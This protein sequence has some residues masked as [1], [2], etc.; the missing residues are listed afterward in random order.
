MFSISLVTIKGSIFAGPSATAIGYAGPAS[1]KLSA[2]EPSELHIPF[3]DLSNNPD[4]FSLLSWHGEI[5][6]FVG[7]EEE[8]EELESWAFENR[9][10]SIKFIIG[11]GGTGKSRLA[12]EFAKILNGKGWNAGF[13]DLRKPQS[14]KIY[15]EG[16]LLIVDYPEENINVMK[17]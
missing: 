5:S 14:F 11:E 8:L 2:S 3:Q 7:R 10:I 16:A 15:R 17:Q 12:A 4:I 6:Q 9:N 1:D 13:I